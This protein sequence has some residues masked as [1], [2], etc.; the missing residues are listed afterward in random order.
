MGGFAAISGS[1]WLI[2]PAQYFNTFVP[3]W[4]KGQVVGECL[5]HV[6]GM[7]KIHEGPQGEGGERVKET[8]NI[9]RNDA[10][11]VWSSFGR[12]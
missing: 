9:R 7:G 4:C 12:A 1:L 11:G 2:I 10:I 6:N 3:K 8:E 5:P